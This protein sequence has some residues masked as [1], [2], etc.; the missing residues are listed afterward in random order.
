MSEA[1]SE[2]RLNCRGIRGATTCATE[3][4]SRSPFSKPPANLLMAID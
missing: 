3:N 4:S 1:Q 2:A